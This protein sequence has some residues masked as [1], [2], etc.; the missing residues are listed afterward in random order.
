MSASALRAGRR[1]VL[2]QRWPTGCSPSTSTDAEPLAARA[3]P[4]AVREAAAWRRLRARRR[5]PT[6]TNAHA[7]AN[8]MKRNELIESSSWI[9][10]RIEH[11]DDARA[12]R[13]GELEL[14]A[15]GR[16][17]SST[18]PVQTAR[19]RAAGGRR[20]LRKPSAPAR[21]RR[22]S[23]R[24]RSPRETWAEARTAADALRLGSRHDR[25]RAS[26]RPPRPT[27][28]PR[29]PPDHRQPASRCLQAGPQRHPPSV[30]HR[31]RSRPPGY[32]G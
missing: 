30:L 25:A 3:D 24:P 12:S 1:H 5:R 9:E 29:A 16:L 8:R 6:A 11:P 21:R 31:R 26:R 18:R 28:P 32:G 27:T 17:G 19:S 2:G 14:A 7:A 23:W 10:F 20:S 15:L 22:R 4:A 13:R